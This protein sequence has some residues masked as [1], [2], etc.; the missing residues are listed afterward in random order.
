MCALDWWYK[1]CNKDFSV[2]SMI[3]VHA[4][5]Y[6]AALDT[7]LVEQCP[8][9]SRQQISNDKHTTHFGGTW[10]SGQRGALAS[11]RSQVRI[12]A[13]AVNLTFPSDLQ[14]IAWALIEFACLPCYPGNTLCSQRLEPPRRAGQALYKSPNLHYLFIFIFVYRSTTFSKQSKRWRKDKSSK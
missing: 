1:L 11:W 7:C 9:W 6:I 13:V 8:N 5:C 10:P 14:L 12:P 4:I 3:S 2:L